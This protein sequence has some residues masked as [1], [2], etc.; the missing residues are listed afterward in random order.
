MPKKISLIPLPQELKNEQIL[1][2]EK[3]KSY[4]IT[5]EKHNPNP[6]YIILQ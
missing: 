2:T 4:L 6:E 5:L 3:T 1:N